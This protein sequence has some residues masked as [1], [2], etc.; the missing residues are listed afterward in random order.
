LFFPYKEK[1]DFPVIDERWNFICKENDDNSCIVK[2]KIF[3]MSRTAK[4]SCQFQIK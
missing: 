3:R 1:S 4:N 2:D